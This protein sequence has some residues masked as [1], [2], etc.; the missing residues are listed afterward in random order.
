MSLTKT[1]T[2]QPFIGV[3]NVAEMSL[4]LSMRAARLHRLIEVDAP[5]III[6]KEVDGCRAFVCEKCDKAIML[7]GSH[8][9]EQHLEEV[10]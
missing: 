9:K 5:G 10:E 8:E 3:H 4:M 6:D 2:A 7:F 1:I